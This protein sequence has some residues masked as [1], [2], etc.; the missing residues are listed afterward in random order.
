MGGCPRDDP[1]A[2]V[3]YR[4]WSPYLWHVVPDVNVSS[5]LP[6]APW[7]LHHHLCQID[8]QGL[9][10]QNWGPALLITAA[11]SILIPPPPPMPDR[12]SGSASSELRLCTTHHCCLQHPD[13]STTTCARST[14]RVCFFRTEVLYYCVQLIEPG[15]QACTSATREATKAGEFISIKFCC[16]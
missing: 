6:P 4:C 15:S 16:V 11:S 14:V 13:P 9:L 10:L 12:R 1:T 3:G 5:L 8:A 2:T 7:S